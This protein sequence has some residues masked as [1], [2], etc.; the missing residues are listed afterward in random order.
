M[1]IAGEQFGVMFQ[2]GRANDG[3]GGREFVLAMQ[4]GGA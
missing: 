4:F 3:I 1:R 2:R